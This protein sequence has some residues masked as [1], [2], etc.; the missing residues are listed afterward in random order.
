MNEDATQQLLM[1]QV[2]RLIALVEE[3]QNQLRSVITQQN[4][5]SAQQNELSARLERLEVKVDQRLYDTRP[6]WENVQEQLAELDRKIDARVDELRNEFNNFR[7]E[8]RNEFNEFRAELRA[9][10][11]GF[12]AELRNEF[13]E[14]RAELRNE[15]NDFRAEL[16]NEIASGFR[17]VDRKIGVLSKTLVDMTAEMQE[18]RDL[19]EKLESQPA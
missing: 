3:S 13:N 5:L 8:L 1:T 6:I 19:I 7:A 11:S 2:N 4:E 12:R 15:F 17:A 18:L 10:S 14:F 16:R 9:E